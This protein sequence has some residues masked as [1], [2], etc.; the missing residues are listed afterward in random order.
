MITL[1]RWKFEQDDE[2]SLEE[3]ECKGYLE[4]PYEYYNLGVEHGG[5]EATLE[6]LKLV[7][8][9][10][11]NGNMLSVGALVILAVLIIVASLTFSE[12]GERVFKKLSLR[13]WDYYKHKGLHYENISKSE[14][15]RT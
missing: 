11:V 6:T 3:Q 15:Y 8:S 5:V 4:D 12:K 14:Y 9:K 13:G 7:R 1:H 2:A 10:L